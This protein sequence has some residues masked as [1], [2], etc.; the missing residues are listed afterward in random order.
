VVRADDG[1]MTLPAEGGTLAL[2]H[3]PGFV[4]AW[5]EGAPAPGAGAPRAIA[6]P[7][8][9]RLD[10][11]RQAFRVE[12][13]EPALLAVRVGG[14]AS[15]ALLPPAGSAAPA[16]FAAFPQR[17]RFFAPVGAGTIEFHVAGLAGETPNGLAEVTL[18]P[19]P[20]VGDGLGAA[21]VLP[22]GGAKAFAFTLDERRDVGLGVAAD[23][24]EVELTLHRVTPAAAL[25]GRGAVQ[26]RQL[27][28]GRYVAVVEAP[29]DA[30]ATVARLGIVGLAPPSEGPP[31]SE[32]ARFLELAGA[33]DTTGGA[34]AVAGSEDRLDP[35]AE[36]NE[37]QDEECFDC[38][39]QSWDEAEG[40]GR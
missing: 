34:G 19:I 23:G 28:P 8:A 38:E 15:I 5:F 11:P 36:E 30:P 25:V 27:E 24:G 40:E 13:R 29:D 22:S 3:D 18:E 7:V 37:A 32:V 14:P 33:A 20:V 10:A 26:R 31:D 39:D 6:P 21:F 1:L 17:T 2:D 4:V 35:F 12:S 9:V 16:T